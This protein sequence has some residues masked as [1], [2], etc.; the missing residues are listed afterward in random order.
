M[1]PTPYLHGNHDPCPSCALRRETEDTAPVLR[2]VIP[3]NQC[4]GLGFLPLSSA[5]I[6]QRTC[7]HARAWYWPA[8][9]RAC[10]PPRTPP[11]WSSIREDQGP[12][13]E[14]GDDKGRG[15]ECRDFKGLG[16]H[17]G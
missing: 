12:C 6:V 17:S 7:E 9:D 2:P 4:A 8:F 10:A 1:K 11:S 13:G 5:E 3:C 16:D 14:Y 15:V